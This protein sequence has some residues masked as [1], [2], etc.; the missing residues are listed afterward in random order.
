MTYNLELKEV[1]IDMEKIYIEN[2]KKQYTKNI[3]SIF[4]LVS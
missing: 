1:L 3:W 2:L 4:I